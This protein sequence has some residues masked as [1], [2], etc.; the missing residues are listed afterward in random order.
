MPLP[1]ISI[2]ETTRFVNRGCSA[3]RIA[4]TEQKLR[5]NARESPRA[6]APVSRP[7]VQQPSWSLGEREL[8]FCF[9]FP[10]TFYTAGLS[11]SPRFSFFH[12]KSSDRVDSAAQQQ[13]Q[14]QQRQTS[15][16]PPR[17]SVISDIQCL[18]WKM[19]I[20]FP[21]V[22]HFSY[23]IAPHCHLLS[24]RDSLKFYPAISYTLY[25]LQQ[26]LILLVV[27]RYRMTCV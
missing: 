15:Q 26:C 16:I 5:L 27:C 4:G 25:E 3:W 20:F 21:R 12:P 13:Q 1:P 23:F 14:Q 24:Q 8:R 18:S 19:L 9:F 2:S 6:S 10:N 22:P 17:L 7:E 11:L